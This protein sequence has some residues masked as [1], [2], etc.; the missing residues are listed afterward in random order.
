MIDIAVVWASRIGED[1]SRPR[2]CFAGRVQRI[3][4]QRQVCTFLL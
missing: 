4:N 3:R 1:N 2:R